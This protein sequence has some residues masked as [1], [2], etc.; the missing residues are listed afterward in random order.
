MVSR[1]R[2]PASSTVASVRTSYRCVPTACANR[3]IAPSLAAPPPLGA[4][5]VGVGVGV[6]GAG[7]V[8]AGVGAGAGFAPPPHPAAASA[9]TIAVGRHTPPRISLVT[10]SPSRAWHAYPAKRDASAETEASRAVTGL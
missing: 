7:V 1:S 9:T 2:D 5:L 3:P 10:L 4:G 6:R 8:G